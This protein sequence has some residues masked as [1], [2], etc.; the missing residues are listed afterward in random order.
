MGLHTQFGLGKFDS[1][2]TAIPQ[3]V[4]CFA[5]TKTKNVELGGFT[6]PSAAFDPV[7]SDMAYTETTP[8]LTVCADFTVSVRWARLSRR[9]FPNP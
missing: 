6:V 5:I 1:W 2:N 3:R 9:L 7:W 8:G 4:P